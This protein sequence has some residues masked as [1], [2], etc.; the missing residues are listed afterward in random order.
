MVFGGRPTGEP[1]LGGIT[2][3]NKRTEI[4]AAVNERRKLVKEELKRRQKAASMRSARDNT[5]GVDNSREDEK[6]KMHIAWHESLAVE[7]V[8]LRT[9]EQR[10][11]QRSQ[12]VDASEASV[13]DTH[14]PNEM[15]EENTAFMND[16]LQSKFTTGI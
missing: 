5:S 14:S 6:G 9:T 1:Q 8:K 3:L 10:K 16:W 11:M 12:A 13:N 4:L 2:M 15:M 7:I